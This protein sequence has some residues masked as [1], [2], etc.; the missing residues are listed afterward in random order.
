M[1][2]KTKYGF[3]PH[4]VY[5]PKDAILRRYV[6]FPD[7]NSPLFKNINLTNVIKTT[8]E[9]HIFNF[10]EIIYIHIENLYNLSTYKSYKHILVIR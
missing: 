8:D 9:S 5:F 1:S 7:S 3:V 4:K 6:D 2:F 10:L